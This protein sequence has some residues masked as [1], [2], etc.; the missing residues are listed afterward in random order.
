[1]FRVH[2]VVPD[3]QPVPILLPFKDQKSADVLKEE[4][5]NLSNRISTAHLQ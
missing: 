3:K 2:P 4:L 5:D 1:M